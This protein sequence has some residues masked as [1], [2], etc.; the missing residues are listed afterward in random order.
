MSRNP[1]TWAAAIAGLLAAGVSVG[2]LNASQETAV[3]GVVQALVGASSFLLPLIGAFFARAKATSLADPKDAQGRR[4]VP[5]GA[6]SRDPNL[7][8]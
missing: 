7:R 6:G 3:N 8:A 2:L 1:V 4:L 5:V